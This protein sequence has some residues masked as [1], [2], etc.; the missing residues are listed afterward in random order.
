MIFFAFLS[1]IIGIPTAMGGVVLAMG[2]G[3][4]KRYNR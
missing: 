4:R 1:M 2:T 3:S